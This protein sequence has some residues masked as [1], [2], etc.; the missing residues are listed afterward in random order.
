MKL[1]KI[2]SACMLSL[3][4]LAITSCSDSLDIIESL[5]FDKNFA[6]LGIEAKN[7]KETSA[8]IQWNASS[9]AT[10]YT[11]EVF[12]DDSLTFE[13][14]PEKVISNLTIDD[15]PYTITGLQFDTK[16][17]IRIQALT[18]GD[19]SRTSSWNGIYFRTGAKQFLK[20]PKPADIADRS[21][22]LT[23]EVEEGYDV[24]TIKIGDIT[25]EITDEEKEA[26]QATIDGLT[27]ETDYTAY[28]YYN[29]KQCGNRNFTTIADL[30]GAILLHEDDDLKKAIEDESVVDGTVF[31]LYGGTYNVNATYDEE[32]GELISTGAVKVAKT[33]T[34]KGIYPTDQPIVKGRFEIYDGAGLS[35]SQLKID[36]SKNSTADQIF[37]YKVE[38]ETTSFGALDIQSCNITGKTE[39]KGLIYMNGPKCSVESI[40]INNST[41]YGIE[42][43]GGDFIDFRTG[44]PK[45]LTV[46]NSTFYNVAK[47]R[48]FFRIDDKSGDFGNPTGPIV[49][50][51]HCTLYN[52]GANASNNRIF[53]V[54]FKKNKIACTNNLIVGT[55]Y[56]RGFANGKPGEGVDPADYAGPDQNPTLSN[57]F[58]FDCENLTS[59]GA[60][61]DATISWF[62]TEGTI[63]SE[64]PFAGDVESGVFTLNADSKA[65]KGGAGD[66]RWIAAQ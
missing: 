51:D 27:P 54:R 45:T 66:P 43:S 21:V 33:I 29:G 36:G 62:D 47:G 46:T 3:A 48:D 19:N 22:T 35:V 37:N 64:S 9:G 16:Y 18:E 6:P 57:N 34:I 30:E 32:T 10:N 12:A 23:W 52:I 11:I 39:G 65:N 5:S 56:K 38:N 17:S 63:E 31:A 59:A 40:I 25:H 14:T 13:G 7:V 53:Y 58:Y 55:K 28:L 44:Y 24:S 20:N 2:A 8:N 41:I 26:G 50:L 42:C 1:Y 60:S 4:G 49:T 15:S 61:A